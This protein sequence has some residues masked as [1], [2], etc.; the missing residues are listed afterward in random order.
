LFQL[1]LVGL[2]VTLG[3]CGAERKSLFEGEHDLPPHWPSN[4][5]DAIQKIDQRLQRLDKNAD[6][7]QAEQELRQLVDWIP[8]VAADEELT[9]EQWMPIYDL[10]EV[11]RQHLSDS[12]VR[13]AAIAPDFRKLQ[14][15]LEK[16]VAELPAAQVVVESRL[17]ASAGDAS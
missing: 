10:C 11:M 14:Q 16:A 9:E 15:L 8:E 2:V 3:A 13:P 17:E 7:A 6:D 5:A 1:S 12:S 4:M